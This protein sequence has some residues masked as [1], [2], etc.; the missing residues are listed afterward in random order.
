ME[1]DNFLMK[2]QN[3]NAKYGHPS[4]IMAAADRLTGIAVQLII[5]IQLCMILH[6]VGQF[7]CDYS[8]A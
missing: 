8:P 7:D 1:R 2:T 3:T 5:M 4:Q 6:K